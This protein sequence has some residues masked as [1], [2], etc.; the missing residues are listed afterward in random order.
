M[1]PIT[2]PTTVSGSRQR[3]NRP[4]RELHRHYITLCLTYDAVQLRLRRRAFSIGSRMA[5]TTWQGSGS[6]LDNW[7]IGTSWTL[8]SAP[9]AADAAILPSVASYPVTIGAAST[10]TV[11]TLTLNA[12]KAGTSATTALNV[13]GH[14]VVKG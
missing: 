3:R 5:N 10:D 7:N 1:S 8:R 13:Q 11:Q 4:A 2:S 14:L 9:G 6:I 12:P